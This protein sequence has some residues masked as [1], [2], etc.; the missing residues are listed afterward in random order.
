[1]VRRGDYSSSPI[2]APRWADRP[3]TSSAVSTNDTIVAVAT[4]PGQGAV[5]IVR[6]SGPDAIALLLK[7]SRR[8]KFPSWRLVKTEVYD[9]RTEKTL[10]QVLV[11]VMRKPR[12]STGD[13]VV[14]IHGHGGSAN[15]SRLLELYRNLGAR[16]ADPGEFTRRAFINGRLDLAA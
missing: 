8:Q 3:L 2:A 16:L 15:M 10:D 13:D 1:M 9:P 7:S 11:S 4:A 6:L 14:E 5:G 12:S